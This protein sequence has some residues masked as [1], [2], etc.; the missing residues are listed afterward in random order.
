M[1]EINELI[2]SIQEQA[3]EITRLELKLKKVQNINKLL[4]IIILGLVIFGIVAVVFFA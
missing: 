1:Q 3:N 4:T 2:T